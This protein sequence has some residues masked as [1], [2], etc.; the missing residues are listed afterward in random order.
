METNW[1][2]KCVPVS[3]LRAEHV[4]QLI[5]FS[6]SHISDFEFHP[7]VMD[8]TRR[9]SVALKE[10]AEL[11]IM[12]LCFPFAPSVFSF[13]FLFFLPSLPLA[14][15]SDFNQIT[16]TPKSSRW[17]AWRLTLSSVRGKKKV[18]CKCCLTLMHWLFHQHIYKIHVLTPAR[19]AR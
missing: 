8:W 10:R 13:F 18:K 4:M 9:F 6:S 17:S 12:T 15:I 5:Y 19:W 3:A 14:V 11:C 1:F 2:D 16:D 7:P